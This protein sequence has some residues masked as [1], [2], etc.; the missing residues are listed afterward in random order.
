[1]RPA[2]SAILEG[3]DFRL[4]LFDGEGGD[5]AVEEISVDGPS[6][7]RP[8]EPKGP[9]MQLRRGQIHHRHLAQGGWDLA[10][11]LL[12][13]D[14]VPIH[15]KLQDRR[16]GMEQLA[17]RLPPV[18]LLQVILEDNLGADGILGKVDDD[19]PPVGDTQP[20][21]FDRQPVTPTDCRRWR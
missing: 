11:V 13:A 4:T 3:P 6:A 18:L 8:L 16:S 1:M 2:S 21:V 5:V 9:L 14:C 7:V 10:E 19:I 15:D 20:D 12:G 17:R